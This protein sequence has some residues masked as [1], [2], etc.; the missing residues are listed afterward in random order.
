MASLLWG[1]TARLVQTILRSNRGFSADGPICSVSSSSSQEVGFRLA[2]A[3]RSCEI[4]GKQAA[5]VSFILQK[6]FEGY[7]MDMIE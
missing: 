2:Y 5:I 1:T 6:S 3:C 7:R 4:T